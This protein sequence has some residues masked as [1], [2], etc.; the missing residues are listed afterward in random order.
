MSLNE[1]KADD[2]R[3]F[4]DRN[5]G[6]KSTAGRRGTAKS[7][8]AGNDVADK[9]DGGDDMDVELKVYM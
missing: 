4:F 5:K 2:L 3:S 8:Q 6:W 7:P 1:F 9:A